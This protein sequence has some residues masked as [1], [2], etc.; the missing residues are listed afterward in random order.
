MCILF[1][2]LAHS[3][4]SSL[5]VIINRYVGFELCVEANNNEYHDY[6]TAIHPGLSG[7][8]GGLF[9]VTAAVSPAPAAGAWMSL[10]VTYSAQDSL[11]RFFLDGNLIKT[12]RPCR[13]SVQGC[14][15]ILYPTRQDYWAHRSRPSHLTLGGIENVAGGSPP[16]LGDFYRH[17]GLLGM[18]KV[19][20]RA[21]GKEEAARRFQ[22]RRSVYRSSLAAGTAGKGGRLSSRTYWVATVAQPDAHVASIG[23]QASTHEGSRQGEEMRQ[24]VSPSI[25]AARVD[26]NQPGY[27]ALRGGRLASVIVRGRFDAGVVDAGAAAG[28]ARSRYR[29]TWKWASVEQSSVTGEVLDEAGEVLEANGGI[30]HRL[31][32]ALPDYRYGQTNQAVLTVSDILDGPLLQ[33]VC[34]D[35]SCGY[36]PAH[37]RVASPIS[38]FWWDREGVGA[39]HGAKVAFSFQMAACGAGSMSL[40][41]GAQPWCEACQAGK[42]AN[43]EGAIACVTC[44]QGTWS[45]DGATA[46][47]QCPHGMSTQHKG[48]KSPDLCQPACAPGTFGEQGGLAPCLP[49]AAGTFASRLGSTACDTCPPGFTS[50]EPSGDSGATACIAACAPGQVGP[51]GTSPCTECTA[52]SYAPQAG[53]EAC[54]P[55]S[56][57]FYSSS[58]SAVCSQCPPACEMALLSQASEPEVVA[59]RTQ[60]C[61]VT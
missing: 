24:Q 20:K 50:P 11:V 52:G 60:C 58:G 49:C 46:C 29:C 40:F 1:L 43:A 45:V 10:V 27:V 19:F 55:C 30:G 33:R 34:L 47:S 15:P 2:F 7:D 51:N 3:A 22:Q 4:P 56:V 48:A 21:L 53:G 6:N 8:H 41:A 37:T 38:S 54:L 59:L 23:L 61:Q 18:V 39:L 5:P 12:Q 16:G 14:G 42:F 26:W 9:L 35:R 28:H 25:V 36:S 32:C 57:G 31:R 13:D 17:H 44:G